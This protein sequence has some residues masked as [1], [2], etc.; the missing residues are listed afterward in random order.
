[1][2]GWPH[3]LTGGHACLLEVVSIGSITPSCTFWLKS[4]H[5]VKTGTK[6]GAETEPSGDCPPGDPS[7]L[8]TPPPTPHPD[9]V[10]V[11]K[12]HLLTGTWYRCSWKVLPVFDQLRCGC[13]EPTIRL[14]SGTPAG[15]LVEELEQQPH[16]KKSPPSVPGDVH[17]P[18]SVEEGIHGS[19]Q[20]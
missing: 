12:R 7:C 11:A 13:L 10:A 18:R 9:T 4:Y 14:S 17:Q 8:Q 6:I 20:Q 1:M 19:R 15:N 16:K 2:G 3:L 5:K